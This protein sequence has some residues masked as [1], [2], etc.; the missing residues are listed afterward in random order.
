MA[1]QIRQLRVFFHAFGDH[2]QL[3]AVRHADDGQHNGRVVRIAGDFAHEGDIDLQ[4]VDGEAL[5]VGQAGIA[6]AEIV[7]GNLDAQRL[8]VA[9]HGDGFLGIRHQRAFRQLQ[10]QQVGRDV[11]LADRLEHFFLQAA[12]KKLDARD[13]HR[14]V[15]GADAAGAPFADLLAGLVEHPVPHPYD[16]PRLFQQGDEE[17]R[18]HHAVARAAPAY[19]GLGAA[20]APRDD[21]HLGLEEQHEFLVVDGAPQG[22]FHVQPGHR[23]R[24]HFGREETEGVAARFLGAVHGRI[25]ILNQGVGVDA[26]VGIHGNA[27]AD[28]DRHFMALQVERLAHRFADLVD[29]AHGMLGAFGQ[30]QDGGEFIAAEAADGIAHAQAVDQAAG[31]LAQQVVADGV[32]QRV[33]DVLEAV[34]VHEQHGHGPLVIRRLHQRMRER[35]VEL[36]AVRQARQGVEMGQFHQALLGVLALGD[37]ARHGHQ[38]PALARTQG[39]P[40]HFH[41]QRRTVL[42][43]QLQFR[44]R[45]ALVA[46]QQLVVQLF[47]LR[48]ALLRAARPGPQEVFALETEHAARRLVDVDKAHAGPV[49]EENRIRRG[50]H[51][52]AEAAQVFVEADACRHVQGQLLVVALDFVVQQQIVVGD[53]DLRGHR[54]GDA[55][56]D[57]GKLVRAQFINQ[58]QPAVAALARSDGHAQEGVDGRMA[59]GQAQRRRIALQAVDPVGLA[60]F[61][62]ALEDA[63]ARRA[64][65]AFEVFLRAAR[66]K[67]TEL[68]GPRL[69]HADARILGDADILRH[70][71][72]RLDQR[73]RIAFG[74]QLDAQFNQGRQAQ[75]DGLQAG[76]R[77]RQPFR[78]DGQVLRHGRVAIALHG[79]LR[80]LL[81]RRFQLVQI[82][83]DLMVDIGQL[84]RTRRHGRARHIGHRGQ[85]GGT[86]GGQAQCLVDRARD[87]IGIGR[88]GQHPAHAAGLRQQGR[89][90]FAVG[91]RV[92][93]DGHV[94]Q[95]GVFMHA[96]DELVA[97]H[98]RH[99]DVGD[100]QVR[101]LGAHDVE[102]IGA[103]GRF[104]QA[105]AAV[106]Q[107]GCEEFAVQHMIIDD[108][109]R[110]YVVFNWRRRRPG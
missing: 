21:M 11:V 80:N 7:D 54:R 12:H 15:H 102:R 79:Q 56:V 106:A 99:E 72:A 1:P 63:H 85:Q 26:I 77:A 45:A 84:V 38:Y 103:V 25:G 2:L 71:A 60:L 35:G 59:V 110:C 67:I 69:Q 108:Q 24:V 51:G 13:I 30:H 27:D 78:H 22:V 96:R 76:Q 66:G 55:L 73:A 107:Q 109:Y 14:Q 43:L 49:D 36:A 100:D 105:V 61:Q 29:H 34:H 98:V 47:Q 82:A 20:D 94:G 101:P 52:Q 19:Q 68:V 6:G 31:K 32:A 3:H 95:R 90:F 16:Q 65:D 87:D 97:I 74:A 28:R 50:I 42:A 83:A 4:L 46:R 39:A 91:G 9:Q 93:D 8:E 18:R 57:F 53:G 58:V 92:E 88:L 23:L 81:A 5:Q 48:L 33:I 17:G 41:G 70:L 40:L 64:G 104:Q 62:Q 10:L 89:F 86:R 44:H 37:V 75:A